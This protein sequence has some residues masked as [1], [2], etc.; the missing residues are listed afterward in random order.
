MKISNNS[1]NELVW[2]FSQDY[3]QAYQHRFEHLPITHQVED[4][5][6]PCE[7]G[8]HEE[9]FSLWHPIKIKETL[10]FNN[11]ETAL[12]VTIHHD[13]KQYFT[14]MYSDSLDASCA[15]GD[16]SL[17]FAWSA[18]DFARLQ[19]NIIGHI[20]MKTKLKQKLTI[21]FATTDD[22]NHI[23]SLDND[24]GEIWVEKVGCEPH[25][26]I[27]DTL[28]EFISQLAPRIPPKAIEE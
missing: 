25:K 17:L 22:D 15:E 14:T 19:E 28:V 27:A 18:E 12:E 6:S 24:S 1:L 5:P 8:I 2:N 26:K 4:W 21:F 11:V 9:E 16:L 10:T 20:L 7:Q 23:I 13:I 3:L